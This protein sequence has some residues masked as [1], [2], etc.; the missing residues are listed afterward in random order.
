MVA[1]TQHNMYG[2]CML[3]IT[4]ATVRDQK[5]QLNGETDHI[6]QLEN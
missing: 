6:Q 2:V 5:R 1:Y 3:K 4:N